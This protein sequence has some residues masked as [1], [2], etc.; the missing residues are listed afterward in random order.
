MANPYHVR[1][2]ISQYGDRFRSE[3]F[4]EDLG[5]TSGDLLPVQWELLDDDFKTYLSM[6]AVGLPPE[7]AAKV[8][9]EIFRQLLG[10]GENQ[11]KWQEVL[12]QSKRQNRPIRLLIDAT[13]DDVRDLPY[14]LL[15]DPHDDF[16]LLRRPDIQFVRIIRRCTP[17]LLNLGKPRLR[18]LVVTAEPSNLPGFDAAKRL[19][20]IAQKLPASY[21]LYVCSGDRLHLIREVLS[22]PP[23]EW[24]PKD[25][26]RFCG[27]SREVLKT[28]L[29]TEEFDILH[30]LCHGFTGGIVLCNDKGERAEVTAREL[31][32]W[33]GA[34]QHQMAFLQV[35]KASSTTD[36]GSFGGVAQQ[37]MNPKHGNM[38]AVI[39]SAYPVDAEL[40]QESV[41][42]FYEGIAKGEPPDVALER[43]LPE[44]NW[45][46]AF[47]ELWVRPSALA[48]SGSRGA[49]QF[50]SPYKGLA[51]FEERD[52]DIFFGRESE[53]AELLQI[54]QTEPIVAIVGDSGSGKSSLVQAGLAPQV[55]RQGLED[56]KNWQIISLVPGDEP[57]S[58]LLAALAGTE[59]RKHTEAPTD[60]LKLLQA[61][62]NAFFELP[63]RGLLILFSQFEEMFALCRDE[64]QRT[65]VAE[66]LAHA[67]E[68]NKNQFRLVMD[69]RSEFGSRV[70][71]LPG[72]T[73]L[74]K[75]P[76]VL[77]PPSPDHIRD[78]VEKPATHF[79]YSFQGP[80]ADG[81][82][83]HNQSLLDR[84][85]ND[86]LLSSETKRPKQ[87]DLYSRTPTPLPL[88]EFALERLWLTA[89]DRGSQEFTHDDYDRLGGLSG[90]IA[91]HAEDV[92]ISVPTRPEFQE[93]SVPQSTVEQQ[94]RDPQVIA[95]RIFTGLVSSRG[96]VTTRRPRVRHD[97]EVESGNVDV[98]R[99]VVDCLVGERLLAIRSDSSNLSESRVSIAHEVLIHWPRFQSWLSENAE[100]R[101]LKEEFQNDVDRWQ[102]GSGKRAPRSRGNLPSVKTQAEYLEWINV[103][104]P[105]LTLVQS[106]FVSA[107]RGAVS[108]NKLF[109]LGAIAGGGW[110]LS[111]MVIV[112]FL[113]V[114]YLAEKRDAIRQTVRS[115]TVSGVSA[116]DLNSLQVKAA[117][118]FTQAAVLSSDVATSRNRQ[119]AADLLVRN[120]RLA[121]V[122]EH[123]DHVNGALFDKTHDRILTWSKDKTLRVWN[124]KTGE[125]KS[126][127]M[128]HEKAVGGAAFN[129][130]ASLI[131]S[132]SHDGTIRIWDAGTGRQLVQSMKHPGVE[133]ARFNKAETKVL[134]WGNEVLPGGSDGTLR[135]WDAST[136]KEESISPLSHGKPV[137]GAVFNDAETRVLSWGEKS[138]FQWDAVSGTQL[139]PSMRHDREVN[140]AAF[141]A[142]DARILSWGEDGAIRFWDADNTS[143]AIATMEH[144]AAVNGAL[145]LPEESMVLSW[146]D[147]ATAKIWDVNKPEAAI[148][149]MRH[150][151]WVVVGA[152][153]DADHKKVLTWGEDGTARLW[154]SLYTDE[155][156][157]V[158]RHDDKVLG[159]EFADDDHI[160][161]WSADGTAR[162]WEIAS[163]AHLVVTYT[164]ND[165]VVG[166]Q[167]TPLGPLTWSQDGSARLWE[168]PPNSI[169][170]NH[171]DIGGATFNSDF[172]RF[173]TWGN[174]GLVRVWD[175]KKTE[176]APVILEHGDGENI[177]NG[178][179]FTADGS[180]IMS[181][182]QDGTVRCWKNGKENPVDPKRHS[183]GI[184]GALFSNVQTD[185]L[186]WSDDGSIQYWNLSTQVIRAKTEHASRVVNAR[187]DASNQRVISWSND[188][189]LRCWD[190]TSSKIIASTKHGDYVSDAVFDKD[191]AHILSCGFDGFARIWNIKSKQDVAASKHGGRV[192][193]AIFDSPGKRVL[194]WSAD[195]AVRLWNSVTGETLAEYSH[196]AEVRGALFFDDES[197]ALS[198]SNDSTLQI[199]DF[200]EN[201]Q[202]ASMRHDDNVEGALLSSDQS[203]I[204][205]W[206]QDRTARLW[207]ARTGDLIATFH[208]SDSVKGVAWYGEKDGFL[209]WSVDG[210]VRLWDIT[211]DDALPREHLMQCLEVRT[212]TFMN[213]AGQVEAISKAKWET[214][215]REY[216]ALPYTKAKAGD[217]RE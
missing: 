4:T 176:T 69:M 2:A 93:D 83:Q 121:A 117:H 59:Q 19:C 122:L 87:Q 133:G 170:M 8:G 155:A 158:M 1:L 6:G 85:L 67:A 92:Y 49:F 27:M 86:P 39:A 198:W 112:A 95:E 91:Q 43:Q 21:D 181:W 97:L 61:A 65:A 174:K 196:D 171:N 163:G 68:H 76:W 189:E 188:G 113:T 168:N 60:W 57:A 58:N 32:T 10:Q 190:T 119:L 111:A 22:G 184:R 47:L 64:A 28:L 144:K 104:K 182:S 41:L 206:S 110:A 204:C 108:R 139:E 187:L 131:L 89:V 215:R 197:R 107:M 77:K 51:R 62:L 3:L 183:K 81:S 34:R 135:L 173:L 46:W 145:F 162:L 109:R 148:R 114:N 177:V 193:G 45:S 191:N 125:P 42:K 126:K 120:T 63:G 150:D 31:G 116:R 79:G 201:I 134:S 132:W 138:L 37:L 103:S 152:K 13:T 90:A 18:M 101:A 38:A 211:I 200:N 202:V 99:K 143:D 5:D 15:C 66:A 26:E 160:L 33:C 78:I 23:K 210:N 129:D 147:D 165:E 169:E 9:Q 136:C 195:G 167:V 96:G 130:D 94:S 214:N 54:L 29:A 106:D 153:F 102:I 154:D 186:S 36:R 16:Y 48:D 185:V 141:V 216:D 137:S 194:S 127:T 199:W 175:P 40:S 203:L 52:A 80:I 105:S 88:L 209:S 50:A 56:H 149:E 159:A 178:A 7:T 74:V 212:G 17:R 44:T 82:P 30:F 123:A 146:A 142:D 124:A 180:R 12:Q 128:E 151:S 192:L 157:A 98:A 72:L 172:S 55:R 53:T 20:E 70:A 217:V 35:C 213:G 75:R 161:T 207:D 11:A 84:I 208:H 73:K 24:K 179:R 156:D 71:A 25:F 115:K 118:F 140:G 164:H 205:S 14:G 100:T 166:A